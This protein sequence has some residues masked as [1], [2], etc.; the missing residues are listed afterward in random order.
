M[1]KFWLVTYMVKQSEASKHWSSVFGSSSDCCTFSDLDREFGWC[2]NERRNERERA[3]HRQIDQICRLRK[4]L[5]KAYKP[6]NHGLTIANANALFIRL[7][8]SWQNNSYHY[9]RKW[10][11]CWIV[12]RVRIFEIWSSA[13]ILSWFLHSNVLVYEHTREP[14]FQL[15][16]STL[17]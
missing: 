4:G 6:S 15:F 1:K 12:A 2:Q 13:E 17:P 8:R 11:E 3:G 10:L 9:L 5:I 16:Y 7:I 14:A